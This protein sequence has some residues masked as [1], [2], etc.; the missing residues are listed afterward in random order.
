[1]ILKRLWNISWSKYI[2]YNYITK[3]VRREGKG[4]IIPY[5]HSVL[6]LGN[7]SLIILHDGNFYINA[8][9]P[10]GS[11]SEAFVL[12]RDNAVLELWNSSQLCYR[13]TIEIHN[14]GKI[15]IGSAYFN[16]DSVILA[17]KSITIGDDTMFAREVYIY[18]SD[19][20]DFINERGEKTNPPKDV[21][22]GNHVWVGMKSVLLRGTRIGDGGVVAACS[23]VGGKVKGGTLVQGNPARAYAEVKWRV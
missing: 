18:D 20:H 4:K 11:K 19:H 12:L 17:E 7:N 8:Y 10:A 22:I 14:N 15:E 16:S 9:R 5:R 2:Y 1:M 3:K 13:S 23:L 21:V 6:N